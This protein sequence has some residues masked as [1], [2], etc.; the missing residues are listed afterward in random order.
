MSKLLKDLYIFLQFVK[1]HVNLEIL[2]TSYKGK[3]RSKDF[4]NTIFMS[5]CENTIM[6]RILLQNVRYYIMCYCYHRENDLPKCIFW[7]LFQSKAKKGGLK[8]SKHEKIVVTYPIDCAHFRPKD[9]FF[10]KSFGKHFLPQ[11]KFH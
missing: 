2:N 5:F 7:T 10:T 4:Y 8:G 11:I 9:S 1:I 6:V 3:Q